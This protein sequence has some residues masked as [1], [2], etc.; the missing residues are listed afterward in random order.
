MKAKFGAIFAACCLL[1]SSCTSKDNYGAVF[2]DDCKDWIDIDFQEGNGVK[3]EPLDEKP[4][5]LLFTFNNKESENTVFNSSFELDVD[6]GEQ[7]FIVYTFASTFAGDYRLNDIVYAN[8]IITIKYNKK[9]IDHNASSGN[10][11]RPYQ[12]WFGLQMNILEA[13]EITFEEII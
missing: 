11:C 12:R 4:T 1:F 5:E 3:L 7:M 2:Y 9:Y 13:K 6:Y 10:A 8:S